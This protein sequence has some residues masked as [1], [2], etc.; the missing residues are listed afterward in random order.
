M[1]IPTVNYLRDADC[2]HDGHWEKISIKLENLEK[3]HCT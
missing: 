1:H 2:E 3:N